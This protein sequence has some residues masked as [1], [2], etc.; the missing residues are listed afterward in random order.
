MVIFD[1]T[2]HF[3]SGYCI[4]NVHSRTVCKKTIQ[5][6]MLQKTI[7]FMIGLLDSFLFM[8]SPNFLNQ[9][10]LSMLQCT[11]AAHLRATLN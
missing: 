4:L 10:F 8:G 11:V 6:K 1:M 3:P 7:I 5:Q 9:T 2:R